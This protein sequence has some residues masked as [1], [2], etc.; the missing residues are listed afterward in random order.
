TRRTPRRPRL[1][2]PVRRSF[3]PSAS[4]TARPPRIPSSHSAADRGAVS[5]PP[6]VRLSSRGGN[7]AHRGSVFAPLV[8]DDSR[9]VLSDEGTPAG[10]LLSGDQRA[11]TPLSDRQPTS[12]QPR[13][14]RPGAGQLV[15]RLI[16]ASRVSGAGQPSWG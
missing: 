1:R 2:F 6:L 8:A 9:A 14:E 13:P 16:Q 10:A 12:D 15:P 3:A 5:G 11:T 4:L 7:A